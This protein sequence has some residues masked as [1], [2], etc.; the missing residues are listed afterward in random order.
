[1]AGFVQ[2]ADLKSNK[3]NVLL[4]TF[5]GTLVGSHSAA[6]PHLWLVGEQQ[7]E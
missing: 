5:P 7:G 1:M 4:F 6:S 2:I 3:F